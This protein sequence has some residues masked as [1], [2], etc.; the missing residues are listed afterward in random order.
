MSRPMV[1]ILRSG[2]VMVAAA[3][4]LSACGSSDDDS[5]STGSTQ[6]VS[7]G[8]QTA[9]GSAASSEGFDLNVGAVIP[10]TG[11]LASYGPPHQKAINLAL[12]N[13]QKALS[14]NQVDNVDIKADIADDQTTQ[15]G[16]VQA[17]RK[18]IQ[19][20]AGCV[21]G[22]LSSAST[23]A[24]ANGATIPSGVP[25]ISVSS[26]DE[27]TGLNDN[28]L[29]FRVQPSD[30]LQAPVIATVI[31]EKVGPDGLVSLAGRNDSFGAG[32][33]D[34][35]KK[36]FD[37]EGVKTQG[38]LLYDPKS[39]SY[40]S[41]ASKIVAN[42]PAAFVIIDYPDTF[43]KVAPALLRTGKFLG[44]K[45]LVA[46]AWPP[47][48]PEGIPAEAMEGTLVTQPA[49]KKG[50]AQRT[51]FDEL[52]ASAPGTTVRVTNDAQMFDAATI[53]M[54]AAIAADSGDPREIAK[55]VPNVSTP[56][57]TKYTYEGLDKAIA[58][59]RAGKD[60]DY[61]GVSS[62]TDLDENGD[63]VAGY[64]DVSHYANGKQ[65]FDQQV[66]STGPAS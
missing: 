58:D 41:E 21:L 34:Q 47:E 62:S 50:T 25:E 31:K 13:V 52:F 30:A 61:E 12:E 1:R 8:T 10:L 33:L 37:A 60:I 24:I 57:G 4:A 48:V 44:D 28:G 7:G 45:L 18:V 40:N 32:L 27:I 2:A 63:L 29:I 36:A 35:L 66:E 59:L 56:G 23:I 53:C 3:L 22:A 46:G 39:S 6:A 26:S 55:F 16:A 38:P 19:D 43:T 64:Y 9:G 51:S 14:A 17:A 54:L 11:D 49:A 5:S 15:E 20:D 42:D 65:E